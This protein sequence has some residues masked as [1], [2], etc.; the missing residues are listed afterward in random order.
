MMNAPL[1]RSSVPERIFTAR[2]P[3][4]IAA[5]ILACAVLSLVSTA[6]MRDYTGKALSEH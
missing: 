1:G 2:T 6:L 3:Y 5:Y 4:A